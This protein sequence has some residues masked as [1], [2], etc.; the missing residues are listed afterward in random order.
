MLQSRELISLFCGPGGL[1]EGFKQAGLITRLAYDIDEPSVLTHRHMHP[2]AHALIADLSKIRVSDIVEEWERRTD[3]APLG[4]IG[5]PPCQSFSVSNVHQKESDPRHKLPE[6]YA[7]ILA[8]VNEK[9]SID[10]FVFEN[11]PGLV[12]EKHI[13]RFERF[14]RLF[15]EAGFR[16]FIG[17]LDAKDFGVPQVRPRVFVVGLNKD[18]YPD[19]H[20]EFPAPSGEPPK[21]VREAIGHLPEPAYF[22][23][24]LTPDR[25][26]YHP[27]HWCM[28]PKSAKFFDGSLKPG[29]IMGRSFRVLSWDEPSYT[30]AYGHREVHVHPNCHRRLSVYEAMLLQGFPRDYV[31]KGTLSD[32]IRQVSEAVAPP[33]ARA[34]AESII[35]HLAAHQAPAVVHEAI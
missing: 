34:L 23:R 25:I 8:G 11:V 28:V 27:N 22:S 30:V 5:G 9:Y 16:T 18:K 20:F 13:K 33:V 4:V 14:V 17:G 15:G 1:D 24:D 26:P 3:K 2:E 35:R 29:Q 21:T 31:L 6:H 19:G 12:T 7:R 32:Q 10:F